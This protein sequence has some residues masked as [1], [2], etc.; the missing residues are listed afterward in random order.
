LVL[1]SKDVT[2]TPAL[3]DLD[4]L[5]ALADPVRRR[6]Y[7]LIAASGGLVG[8]DAAAARAGIARSLAAYHLDHLAKAGLL[9]V[10]YR[11]PEG[12]GGPGAGRPAKLYRRAARDFAL[13]T[14]P[15]DYELLA[16]ILLRANPEDVQRSA[17]AIG[18][19]LGR[20]STSLL[21]ALRARGYEP[22]EDE[23]TLRFRNCPFHALV[24]ANRKSVCGLNLAL[25]EGILRGAKAQGLRASLEPLPGHCCVAV[26]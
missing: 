13:R 11:R 5:S 4:A 20:D 18:R 24:E 3:D 12:R 22:Y 6:L 16:Q 15:R 7:E 19:D 17:R 2:R 23:G 1:E 9:E 25:V 21:D 26:R 14:P 8:R 10:E